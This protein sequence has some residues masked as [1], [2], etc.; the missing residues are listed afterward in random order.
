MAFEAVRGTHGRKSAMDAAVRRQPSSAGD[1]QVFRMVKMI[2]WL[3]SF[4]C[5]SGGRCKNNS[6]GDVSLRGWKFRNGTFLYLGGLESRVIP[7]RSTDDPQSRQAWVMDGMSFIDQN[8]SASRREGGNIT[9][10][11][12]CV[13]KYFGTK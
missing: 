2:S 4:P 10:K 11:R 6:P 8:S 7:N 9:R 3:T 5:N 1:C 13:K 12:K